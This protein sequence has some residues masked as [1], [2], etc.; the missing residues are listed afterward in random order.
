MGRAARNSSSTAPELLAIEYPGMLFVVGAALL[1]T[2]GGNDADG[3][4]AVALAACVAAW[5]VE[6]RVRRRVGFAAAAT[7]AALVLML[8]VPVIRLIPEVHGIS[9]WGLVAG[10]GLLLLVVAASLEQTRARVQAAVRHLGELT[11]GWNRSPRIASPSP[12]SAL[13]PQP[14][15]SASPGRAS[16]PSSCSAPPPPRS[17]S[18]QLSADA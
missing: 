1:Q 8:T 10:I 13:A 16:A 5:G 14:S 15:R 18:A 6:T 12:F 9:L 3:L 7:G 17:P 11:E 2:I 4:L